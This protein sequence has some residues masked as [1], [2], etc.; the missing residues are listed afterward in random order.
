MTSLDQLFAALSSVRVWDVQVPGFIDRDRPHPR[1]TPLSESVYLALEDGYLR[2]DSVANYSQLAMRL[3]SDVEVPEALEGEDEEFSVGSFSEPF[4]ADAYDSFRIT[5]IR[6]AVDADSDPSAGVVRCAEFEFE[7]NWPL[8][9]DPAWQFGIRLQ[10]VGAFDRCLGE[11]R[12]SS[13]GIQVFAWA[14]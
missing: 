10:G 6:W 11:M 3:V 9:V 8:C 1:F 14:P 13:L 5:R 7:K 4:L 12:E 2:L